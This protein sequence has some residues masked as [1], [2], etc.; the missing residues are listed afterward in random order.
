MMIPAAFRQ[1]LFPREF[2]IDPPMADLD[3]IVSRLGAL[4][5]SP[6]PGP[7]PATAEPIAAPPE[8][9]PAPPAEA[10]P[11]RFLAE[12]CTGLWR[13]RQKMLQPGTDRPFE[14]MRRAYRH[15]ESTWDSLEQAGVR[16]ID[17]TDGPFHSGLSLKVIAYQ[18]T[19]GLSRERVIET[20]KPSI[21]F[22]DTSIQM[23][24]VIV[25]VPE[26]QASERESVGDRA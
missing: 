23:G 19:L 4:I 13:L 18:P 7:V 8:Q 14:E 25:G 26:T 17:H 11:P 5:A 22:K 10:E 16:I 3:A 2:R 15:F 21:Y 6:A 12:V 9:P 24:E 20:I 1:L